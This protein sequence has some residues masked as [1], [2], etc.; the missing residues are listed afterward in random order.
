MVYRLR[1]KTRNNYPLYNDTVKNIFIDLMKLYAE[2]QGVT[3]YGK[4]F[5]F[6]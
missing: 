3:N 4:L 6:I 2:K 1:H 5:I